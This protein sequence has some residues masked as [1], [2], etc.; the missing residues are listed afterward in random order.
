MDKQPKTDR[1]FRPKDAAAKLGVVRPT[2]YRWIDL[3]LLPPPIRLGLR[4]T[5]WRESALDE[6]LT[7]REAV[8]RA[9]V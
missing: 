7:R 4:A 6:F 5:G 9:A 1:I 2:L 8:G 3:G